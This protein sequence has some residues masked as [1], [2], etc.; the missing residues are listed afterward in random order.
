MFH[1]FYKFIIKDAAKSN[2]FFDTVKFD[3]AYEQHINICLPG[4]IQQ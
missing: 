3:R 1:C 2:S 4:L